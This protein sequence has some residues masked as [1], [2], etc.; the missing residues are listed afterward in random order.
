VT[1]A[2]PYKR[3]AIHTPSKFE[4]TAIGDMR[5]LTKAV[6]EVIRDPPD[7]PPRNATLPCRLRTIVGHVDDMGILPGAMKLLGDGGKPK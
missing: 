2:Y 7:A 6:A 5:L 1:L 3:R 4:S